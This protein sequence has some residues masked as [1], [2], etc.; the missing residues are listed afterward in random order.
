[1]RRLV[2]DAVLAMV[3]HMAPRFASVIL[4]AILGRTIGA[5]SAGIFA[6][7]ISFSLITTTIMRGLDELVVREV[8]RQP[9]AAVRFLI[10]FILLRLVVSGALIGV[11][12]LA[13][14]YVF[15]YPPNTAKPIMLLTVSVL[16]DG[17]TYVAQ[18]VLNG[19][20][21]FGWSA[22]I[23]SLTNAL[24]VGIGAVVH[25]R[26]FGL[27][28]ICLVWLVCSCLGAL[29]LLA[30]A[31]RGVGYIRRQDWLD[32]SLL[33]TNLRPALSFV[34]LTLLLAFE[35]Q[36]DTLV[37]S[38]VRPEAEVGWYGA[39]TTLA[40]GLL[41]LSQ[42]YRFAA[43]PIMS[44]FSDSETEKLSEFY[45]GSIRF[46]V[47]LALP[48]SAGL[49]IAAP[50]VMAALFGDGFAPGVVPLQILSGV[51]L[52]MFINEP[53]SRMLLVKNRQRQA[54]QL[55]ASATIANIVLNLLLTPPYGAVGAALARLG[56][57]MS[58]FIG[59]AF[60]VSKNIIHLDY[61][62]TCSSFIMATL[63]MG[64]IIWPLRTFPL[65]FLA[66]LGCAIY[67]VFII[68]IDRKVAVQARLVWKMATSWTT[69]K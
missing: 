54:L 38:K 55:L 30:A 44:R 61:I 68:I 36:T 59:Y 41:T 37:L 47:M 34:A 20:R 53:N 69:P 67:V 63:V 15:Q 49:T 42:A 6:L 43:Y 64:L 4:F 48:M 39:A 24:K 31:L 1:M 12:G 56:S 22:I 29:A 60:Y 13:I 40:F 11:A 32:V 23:L 66:G 2:R 27:D 26:G 9:L 18:A 10:N 17:V 50:R 52:L 58:L 45:Q 21:R 19:Q 28:V 57:T 5:D 3:P 51:L 65:P 16:P 46:I 7:A 35:A 33:A 25:G 8:A 14:I 62:K